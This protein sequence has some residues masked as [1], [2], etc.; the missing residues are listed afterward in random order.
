MSFRDRLAWLVVF[1]VVCAAVSSISLK[2]Q[3]GGGALVVTTCGT[4]G[5]NFDVGS[6]RQ[7]TVNTNGQVCQ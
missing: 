1:A 5:Q 3:T 2:A 7:L 6:T 4:L